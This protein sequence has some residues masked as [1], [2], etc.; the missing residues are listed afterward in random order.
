MDMTVGRIL[1]LIVIIAVLVV[2][3]WLLVALSSTITILIISL[4]VAYI[5]DPLVSFF[6]QKGLTRTQA[7]TIVFLL[8]GVLM[9]AIISFFIPLL[10]NELQN[11]E[12]AV[13]SGNASAFFTKI[14][15]WL[16][17]HI[18]F[19]DLSQLNLQAKLNET[20][21]TLSKSIFS[22]IGSVVS[23]ITA[24]V[25]IPFA[26]FF[27]LKDGRH[28]KKALIN[29]IPNRYFEM[30]LNL[31]YKT[32]QQLGGYLRGQFFDA[33]IIGLMAI[34]ALWLLDVRYFI[35]IG[36]FAGLANMIPYVGPLTGAV[37]AIIVVLING[38]SGQQVFLV[39]LAFTIIQLL[40]NVLVQPLVVARTVNLHPLLIIFAVIIGGQFF[41]ILGMLLAV[42]VTGMIKVLSVE[43]Y[44]SFRKYRVV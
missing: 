2:L 38:G 41:G 34:F 16:Q 40:D 43:L 39:T 17:R 11:I 3:G 31:I 8:I 21:S 35:L 5:L 6:E 9:A 30:T 14:E 15:I 36:I 4:L 42:P 1:K 27:F 19:M 29:I 7:T 18:T 44:K 23:I 28:M 24:L 10:I 13:A 20:L 33:A 26:V 37:T 32:D 25:I 12:N 22:I